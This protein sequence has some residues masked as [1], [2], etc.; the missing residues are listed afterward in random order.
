MEKAR[1]SV[2]IPVK[3]EALKIKDCI[4][5]ILNQTIK[6]LEII[7]IDSGSTDGTI[8]ILEKYPIVKIIHIKSED[9]NH[10]ETRNLGVRATSGDFVLMT[11][12]DARP[13][14]NKWIE[15]LLNGF[16]DEKVACVFGEQVVPSD[17]NKNPIEWHNPVGKPGMIKFF[18]ENFEELTPYD[19][20]NYCSIDDVT[21][22]Y[23]RE[24][25]I[26]MPYQKVSYGEDIIWAKTA[27]END[28]SIVFNS[29]AKVY[30]YHNTDYEFDFKRTFTVYYFKYVLFNF[31]PKINIDYIYKLRLIKNLFFNNK[32]NVFEKIKWFKYNV[33]KVKAINSA[34][35]M[36]TKIIKNKPE[37]LDEIH[38]SICGTPPIPLKTK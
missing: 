15:H 2:V 6:V 32:L 30:H 26:K 7:I 4:D 17:T 8:E 36:F 1:I 18:T 14:D 27:L 23:K 22:L 5:G 25:L 9:F 11:V 33:K 24:L 38:L 16:D 29:F 21:A 28:F 34:T 20:Q 10:G 13:F 31:V 12:G 19:K 35:K 3:N 37:Q